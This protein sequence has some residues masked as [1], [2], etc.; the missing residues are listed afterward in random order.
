VVEADVND[1]WPVVLTVVVV[2]VVCCSVRG[3][4]SVIAGERGKEG[5]RGSGW[6]GVGGSKEDGQS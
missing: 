4:V 6:V 5:R 2:V 1:G 3:M